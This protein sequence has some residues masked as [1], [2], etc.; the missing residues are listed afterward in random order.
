MYFDHKAYGER[1]KRLRRSKGLTQ[2]QLAEKLRVS[3]TYIGK[4]EKGSQVGSIELAV[5]LAVF[6]GVPLEH[7]LLGSECPADN[8]RRGLQRVIA[9]LSELEAEL[10]TDL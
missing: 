8:R 10:G 4:I 2:E 1:I 7:L 3:R 5:E 6:F 9:F